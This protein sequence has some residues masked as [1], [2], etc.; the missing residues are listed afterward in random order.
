MAIAAPTSWAPGDAKGFLENVQ[1]LAP[2]LVDPA[3]APVYK[4][5]KK[6]KVTQVR[7]DWETDALPSIVIPTPL[8]IADTAVP[9]TTLVRGRATNP[10]QRFTAT[11]NISE[12]SQAIA[13]AG[14]IAGIDDEVMNEIRRQTT[15]LF[16]VIEHV[17]LSEQ[18]AVQD[19]GAGT[20][21]KLGG[22]FNKVTTNMTDAGAVALT[23]FV[24]EALFRAKVRAIYQSSSL[25]GELWCVCR[26]DFAEYVGITF[27]GRTNARETVERSS[28]SVDSVVETY[29]APVGGLVKISADRSIG[30]GVALINKNQIG[31][32]ELIPFRAKPVGA[33]EHFQGTLESYLTLYFGNEKAHGGW[34]N[35]NTPAAA[36]S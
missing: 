8:S 4:E 6:V 11:Y 24:T 34:K 5:T 20:P 22:F 13:A 27:N 32:G 26:P 35:D 14:G 7:Y 12:A 33:T 29:I 21:G 9:S 10:V 25:G 23:T 19:A 36:G 15:T 30:E 3:D 2:L 28:R 1:N 16:A 17:I 18:A 31:V